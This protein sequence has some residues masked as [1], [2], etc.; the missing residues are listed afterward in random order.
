M[1]QQN[2]LYL[3]IQSKDFY[4]DAAVPDDYEIVLPNGTVVSLYSKPKDEVR[5]KGL[6]NQWEQD[7]DRHESYKVSD[8]CACDDHATSGEW[9]T[10]SKAAEILGTTYPAMHCQVKSGCLDAK[11]INGCLH[12]SVDEL[13]RFKPIYQM[14][15]R[16]S[17]KWFE[18]SIKCATKM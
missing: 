10:L 18:G 15:R 1:Q 12:V 5:E 8:A 4:F 13:E 11:N 16:S 17:P 3:E 9:L 14:K 2:D 7:D 6:R